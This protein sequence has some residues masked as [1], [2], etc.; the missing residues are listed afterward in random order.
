VYSVGKELVQSGS[1]D[2]TVSIRIELD[3]GTDDELEEWAG[4][5]HRSKR[6]HLE[7]LVRE[8]LASYKADPFF[9]HRLALSRAPKSA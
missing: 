6:S 9:L 5:E 7:Y 2:E 1:T 3:M 8:A 4:K